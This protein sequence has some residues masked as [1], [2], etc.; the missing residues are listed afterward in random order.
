MFAS[1]PVSRLSTQT[2]R[3]PRAQQ[4]IAQVGAEEAGSRR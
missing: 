1:E 3:L 2:T 4:L